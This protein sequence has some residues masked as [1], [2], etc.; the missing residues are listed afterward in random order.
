MVLAISGGFWLRDALRPKTNDLLMQ[1]ADAT[2]EGRVDT[3][4]GVV[5]Q[6]V[7]IR[8]GNRRLRRMILRDAQHRRQHKSQKFTAEE[9][10]L[11]NDLAQAGVAWDDPLS[12]S[13]YKVW[14]DDQ[15][16]ASDTVEKSGELLTLAAT[17][18]DGE[19][20]KT[21]LTLRASD[22]HPVRRT[23]EF[24]DGERIEIAELSYRVL[25]WNGQTNPLFMPPL[26]P[27]ECKEISAVS[28]VSQPWFWFESGLAAKRE[29]TSSST[30]V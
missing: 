18:R 2:A 22:L 13:S 27:H 5:Y 26:P 29:G 16:V 21:S 3:P 6:S 19:V 10:E 7:E 30:E 14:H 24:R 12:A 28:R 1:A 11:R 8:V 4:P 23:V 17:M 25:P 15:N 9:T 20:A